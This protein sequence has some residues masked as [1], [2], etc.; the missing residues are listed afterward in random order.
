[1]SPRDAEAVASLRRTVESG[2]LY[3]LAAA[4]GG[5]AACRAANESGTITLDYNLK[6]GG[7]LRVKRQPSIEY[8]D[9]EVRFASPLAENPVAVL[10]RAEEAAF[11][12]D[13][14]CI[15]WRRKT[16]LR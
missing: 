14:C 4:N 3:T 9:Q 11:G 1:M 10:T 2:P 12:A 5:I 13:R 15:D 6:D 16:R 7:W 8:T